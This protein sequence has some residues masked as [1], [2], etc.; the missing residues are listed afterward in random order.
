MNPLHHVPTPAAASCSEGMEEALNA[1]LDGELSFEAQPALFAHL[2]ACDRCRRTLAAMMEFRRM[3]RQEVLAVPAAVDDAF[4]RRLDQIKR[5]DA[6]VDRSADRRPLGQRR[7]RVSL[8]AAAAASLMLFV[9]GL[10]F[11]HQAG[12]TPVALLVEGSEERVE[13]RPAAPFRSEAIY[14][15]YPGLTVEATK[16][17]EPTESL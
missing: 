7:A 3:S 11:P 8:R 9:A 15:F 4:F 17:N 12:E 2:A 10:L 13:L 6:H 16:I 1:Y 14:V 5:R